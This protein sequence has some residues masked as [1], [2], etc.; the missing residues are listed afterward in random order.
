MMNLVSGQICISCLEL[1]FS[2][3]VGFKRV[4][5]DIKANKKRTD[6]IIKDKY[7]TTTTS[8]AITTSK[9]KHKISDEKTTTSAS[10]EANTNKTVYSFLALSNFFNKLQDV[11]MNSLL[12]PYGDVQLMMNAILLKW[13]YLT[14]KRNVNSEEN[15]ID[16]S[17]LGKVHE[18]T[19]LKLLSSTLESLQMQSKDHG[20]KVYVKK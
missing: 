13:N 20:S 14:E 2:I 12:N 3:F 18:N 10:I 7:T 15:E 6:N 16:L 11:F 19:M 4:R 8:I 17:V 9:V 1:S 5:E